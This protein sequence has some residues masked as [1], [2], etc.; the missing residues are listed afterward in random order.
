MLCGLSGRAGMEIFRERAAG[1]LRVARDPS[2]ETVLAALSV[3]TFRTALEELVA[4]PTRRSTSAFYQQAAELCKSRLEAFGYQVSLQAFNMAGGSSCNVVAVP[5]GSKVIDVLVTGHLELGELYT[6]ARLAKPPAPTQRLGQRR[7]HRDGR[8]ACLDQGP[9]CRRIHPVW[10]R[11]ARPA[12]QQALCLKPSCDARAVLR[13][14]VNMDMIG[15][16]NTQPDGTP[17]PPGSSCLRG[18]KYRAT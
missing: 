10:R 18:R 1:E 16:L 3:K 14:I 4:L 13:A 8:G 17:V 2:V 7:R 6:T 5:A 11:G 15:T 12:R 9:A